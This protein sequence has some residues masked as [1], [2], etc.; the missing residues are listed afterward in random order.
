MSELSEF[1]YLFRVSPGEHIE[2]M[3]TP[4]RAA[5]SMKVWLDWIRDLETKGHLKNLGRPLGPAGTVVRGS[6][7]AITDG[8]YIEVKDMVAG[9]IIVEARDMAQAVELASACPLLNGEGSVEV[10]PV[11]QMPA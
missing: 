5:Q 10:R 3:G 2:V 6:Q 11:G 1:V 9:F 7:R 8:P 4:E